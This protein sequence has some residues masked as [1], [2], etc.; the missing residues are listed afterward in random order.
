MPSMRGSFG[1][2]LRFLLVGLTGL[3]V[4]LAAGA[5]SPVP[6][7]APPLPNSPIAAFRLLLA[8]DAPHRTAALAARPEKQREALESRLAEYDTLAADQREA[9]LLAT[10]LYWHLQQLLP[11]AA[12]ERA[13]LVATAPSE[14]R[15]ILQER[16]DLWDRLPAADRAMLLQHERAIRYFSR[17]REVTPPPLPGPHGN[18]AGSNMGTP[19]PLPVRVTLESDRFPELT[20]A[21]RSHL[22]G[23][24]RRLFEAPPA[25]LERQLAAKSMTEAE[26]R[27][28]QETL[29]RFRTLSSSQRQVCIESF[30]RFTS[31]SPSERASFLRHA[32]KWASLPPSER[33]AWRALVGKLPPLPP[34]PVRVVPPPLPVADSTS[35]KPLLTEGG[36]AR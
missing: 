32:E 23:T 21:A 25:A 35:R 9:R 4:W 17:V 11:R 14:L 27:E 24:W 16:L 19:P 30:T 34:V 3:W 12:S 7:P 28:M 5:G 1:M 29:D 6:P 2:K 36:K 18:V 20:P 26:R 8:M 31:L 13:E 15:P 33:Q 10:D 22:M